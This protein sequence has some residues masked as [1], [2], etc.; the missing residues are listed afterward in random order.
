[1]RF[2]FFIPDT[3]IARGGISVTL[4]VIE[5]LNTNGIPA[6]AIYDRPDF[7]YN[8]HTKRAP[9]VW[10]QS[11]RQPRDL[12]GLKNKARLIR[13][14][15]LGRNKR[16]RKNA[17]PCAAWERQKDDVLVVP[18]WV[19]EWMPHN[20]PSDLPLVLFN[21]NPFSL[22][23]AFAKPGFEK[24]RYLTSLSVSDACSAG[25][26]MV[27]GKEP[28]T[29]PLYISDELYSFQPQKKFQIA[30]MPRKRGG[31]AT[32]LVKTLQAAPE[33]EGISF[34]PIGGVTTKEAARLIR[35]SLFFLSFSDR[36]GFGLPPAEAM[37][38]GSVVIGYAGVGGDEFFDASTGI[39]VPENNVTLFYEEAVRVIAG[40]RS[41]PEGLDGLRRK[42]SEIIAK[43]YNR[44]NFEAGV[45]DAFSQI[46]SLVRT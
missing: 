24:D 9:R 21:Q 20:L 44:A 5:V 35:E 19:S 22:L 36:E 8:I 12:S 11:M 3:P 13:D 16:P 43:R 14:I 17:E 45:L 10:S 34:V 15:A 40:Y 37:A 18:E 29:F 23:Y 39:L 25:S 46:E 6:L 7:E 28:V 42:A 2:L 33:L 31:E 30:Y 41:N 4:D 27:L 1:M 26:R 32:A 38:T